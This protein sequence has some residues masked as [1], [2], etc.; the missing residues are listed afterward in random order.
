MERDNGRGVGGLVTD[1]VAH[2]T[3]CSG[4]CREMAIY[5]RD[6]VRRGGGVL[7]CWGLWWVVA[8]VACQRCCGRL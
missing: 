5:E 8:V 4:E 1:T 6:G 3:Q 2:A 7:W